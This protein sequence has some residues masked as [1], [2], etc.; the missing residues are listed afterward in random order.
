MMWL[1]EVGAAGVGSDRAEMVPSRANEMSLFG[2]RTIRAV[3][4]CG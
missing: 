4:P 3:I 1:W 2:H